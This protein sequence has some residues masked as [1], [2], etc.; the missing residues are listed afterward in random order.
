MEKLDLQAIGKELEIG[1]GE[2]ISIRV[3]P[4]IRRLK[5]IIQ[6]LQSK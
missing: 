2:D 5:G 4:E 1:L 3:L 6:Q